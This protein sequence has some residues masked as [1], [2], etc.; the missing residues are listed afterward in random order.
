MQRHVHDKNTHTDVQKVTEN[1]WNTRKPKTY[2]YREKYKKFVS[3]SI[4]LATQLNSLYENIQIRIHI[5]N[6]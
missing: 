6:I 4:M 2:S 5:I 1:G 3:T